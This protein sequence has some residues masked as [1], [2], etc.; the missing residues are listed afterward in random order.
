MQELLQRTASQIQRAQSEP[1]L[2]SLI[3]LVHF[4]W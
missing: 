1:D 2:Y 3:V 4:F